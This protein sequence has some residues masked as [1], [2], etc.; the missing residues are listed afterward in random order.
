MRDEREKEGKRGENE[1][2]KMRRRE[3]ERREEKERGK[4]E[5]REKRRKNYVP[6]ECPHS[7]T[8]ASE[9]F[10]RRGSAWR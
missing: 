4:E 2:R 3:E 8:V 7:S 6:S 1:K 9:S 10:A 5:R